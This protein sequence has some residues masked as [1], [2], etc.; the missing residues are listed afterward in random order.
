MLCPANFLAS[1]ATIR[2]P[3]LAKDGFAFAFA[4]GAACCAH[5]K[6]NRCD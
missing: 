1:I 3:S 2:T 4:V 5:F 6:Q